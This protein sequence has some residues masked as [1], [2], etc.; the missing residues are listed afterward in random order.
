MGKRKSEQFEQALQQAAR[1][2][3]VEEHLTSLVHTARE[4]M[5]LSETPPP[6]PHGLQPGRQRFLAHAARLR[7]EGAPRRMVPAWAPRLATGLVVITLVLGVALASG[8]ASAV[9]LPGQPL[10]GVK[11][12]VERVHLALT[13]NPE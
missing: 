11:L 1:G 5:T 12:A 4:V 8:R 13:S 3:S 6:A 9:S 2:Q 10:Y 7:T